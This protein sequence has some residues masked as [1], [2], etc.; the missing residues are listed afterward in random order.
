VTGC[1]TG[2]LAL[3]RREVVPET[4]LSMKEMGVESLRRKGTLEDFLK[5]LK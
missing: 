4:P 2:A 3:V 1:D 5:V